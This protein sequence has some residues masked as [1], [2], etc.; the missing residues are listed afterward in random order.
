MSKK[1]NIDLFKQIVKGKID[2][3]G[4]VKGKSSRV[5]MHLCSKYYSLA[6][7]MKSKMKYIG[8]K[9]IPIIYTEGKTDQ[10][11]LQSALES[12]KLK[13]FYLDLKLDFPKDEPTLGDTKL[14]ERM[15]GE[16]VRPIQNDRPHIFLFDR[17]NKKS[18][19]EL[20]QHDDFF[21]RANSV[22]SMI[23]PIP[24]HRGSDSDVC[25][26]LY[27]PDDDLRACDEK[28][29]RLYLSNEFDPNTGEH[30]L[31]NAKCS[32]I[33]KIRGNVKIISDK[34]YDN[35][36]KSLSLS[37]NDFA[38]KI[39]EKLKP[40]DNVDFS[41]FELLFGKI[42]EIISIFDSKNKIVSLPSNRQSLRESS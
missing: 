7:E 34:V 17:D 1:L 27:Y 32:S 10:K 24:P 28:G 36:G 13:G 37:K 18:I 41:G 42:A 26:E 5:F 21:E 6:P 2:F 29:R 11:H 8:S 39:R 23:L 19:E 4:M 14:L 35:S 22:F 9:T 25:I 33:N 12:F 16:Q 30:F 15:K 20:S 31:E 40:F 38:E 3:V